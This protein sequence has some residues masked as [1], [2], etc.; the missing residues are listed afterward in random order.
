MNDKTDISS[1]ERAGL[2]RRPEELV[3]RTCYAPVDLGRLLASS[4]TRSRIRRLPVAQLYYGL[5]ELSDDQISQLLPHITEEQWT[6]ILDLDL[7]RRDRLSP[8]QF[9]YRQG[10]ISGAHDAVAKKLIRAVEEEIWENAFQKMLQI[11]VRESPDQVFDDLGP[12]GRESLMTPDDHYFLVL[13]A[14]PEAARMMRSLI[15]RLYELDPERARFLLGMAAL[16]TSTETQELAYQSRK[17]RLED[18]G[19]QDYYDA[20][21]IYTPLPPDESLPQKDWQPLEDLSTL[22]V[23]LPAVEQGPYLLLQAFAAIEDPEPSLHLMEELAFLC[24]KVLSADQVS[25]AQPERLKRRIRKT[26]ATIS[27]GLDVWSGGD[28]K[29]ASR[30]VQRHFLQSFFQLGYGRLMD[31]QSRARR[32]IEKG[33]RL[34]PGSPPEA[35][36]EGFMRPFPLRTV[37]HKG[38]IRRR[39][40]RSRRD[41][42]KCRNIL[43]RLDD[44]C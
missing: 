16:R 38:K 19:F 30:G 37:L 9:L 5:R 42:E 1:E 6:G 32:L 44:Q 8:G 27:L 29:K 34:R 35:A 41:L 23:M 17:S 14:K 20:I 12:K 36:L 13:P 7:W 18:L 11:H 4:E 2:M 22:P 10:F 31:L 15:L 28:L 43:R 24:N 3:Y 25:P 26:V 40:L 39:F 33:C 21:E